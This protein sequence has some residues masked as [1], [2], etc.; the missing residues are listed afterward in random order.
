[1]QFSAVENRFIVK[2]KLN[3]AFTNDLKSKYFFSEKVHRTRT[4]FTDLDTLKHGTMHLR[5]HPEIFI[6]VH[7]GKEKIEC[8]IVNMFLFNR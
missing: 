8:K 7:A 2:L 3:F 1:M 5:H 4:A 6:K